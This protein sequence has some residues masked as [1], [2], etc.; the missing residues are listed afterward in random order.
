M[1]LVTQKA[2]LIGVISDGD[3]RRALE[4][5]EKAKQNPLSL[6]AKDIMTRNPITVPPSMLAIEASRIFESRKIT[7]LVVREEHGQ[8]CGILHVHDLLAAKVL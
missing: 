7:F 5:A 2:H 8:S 4:K 1:T 6:H 3:I